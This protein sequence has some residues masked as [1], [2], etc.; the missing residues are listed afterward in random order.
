MKELEKSEIKS[1]NGCSSAKAKMALKKMFEFHLISFSKDQL[2]EI[3]RLDKDYLFTRGISERV[4]NDPSD[5][6][7]PDISSLCYFTRHS[8]ESAP[9]FQL[10][11]E[12]IAS[13]GVDSIDEKS[14][15]LFLFAIARY[16]ADESPHILELSLKVSRR[17]TQTESVNQLFYVF[18]KYNTSDYDAVNGLCDRFL[19]A[20]Q[21]K[22][23]RQIC[24]AAFNLRNICSDT[25]LTLIL[26]DASTALGSTETLKSSEILQLLTVMIQTPHPE[27][28][29]QCLNFIITLKKTF[30]EIPLTHILVNSINAFSVAYN[31]DKTD[32]NLTNL[33]KQALI[34]I[35]SR[36]TSDQ[37]QKSLNLSLNRLKNK[38]L[39]IHRTIEKH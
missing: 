36:K 7:F 32:P 9:L 1:L 5:L 19:L 8:S 21:P 11:L 38:G 34:L 18:G 33:A 25:R 4:F 6:S 3:A 2:I 15:C 14:I 28:L 39:E 23:F 27:L 22:S 20:N 24:N 13:I 16:G 29:Q 35:S 12:K 37:Q 26:N 30:T 17:V 10:G 31:E